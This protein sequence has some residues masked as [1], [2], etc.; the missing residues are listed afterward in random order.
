MKTGVREAQRSLEE[1]VRKVNQVLISGE[2]TFDIAYSPQTLPI[3]PDR[4]GRTIFVI[5]MFL[6]GRPSRLRAFFAF[7]AVG[8]TA[9]AII[10]GCARLAEGCRWWTAEAQS[11]GSQDA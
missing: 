10:I 11:A 1:V 5:A 6:A 4:E 8:L 9:K 7:V 3:P 2:T